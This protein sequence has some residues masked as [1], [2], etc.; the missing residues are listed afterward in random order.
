MCLTASC[1]LRAPECSILS[2]WAV[3][4]LITLTPL[5]SPLAGLPRFVLLDGSVHLIGTVEV[6]LARPCIIG[7]EEVRLLLRRDFGFRLIL[8]RGRLIG[9]TRLFVAGSAFAV[10]ERGRG[11]GSAAA[12]RGKR[13]HTWLQDKL[14]R[15]PKMVAAVVLANRMTRQIWAMIT[16]EQGYLPNQEVAA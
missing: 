5:G 3:S 12:R 14:D 2:F 9:I 15:K 1:H 7:I 8:L 10:C 16:K 11:L 6:F 13:C 4:I